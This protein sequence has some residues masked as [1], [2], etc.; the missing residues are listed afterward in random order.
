MLMKRVLLIALAVVVLAGAGVLSALHYQNYKTKKTNQA[1]TEAANQ[2]AAQERER[3][4]LVQRQLITEG[5]L[6]KMTAEC[7]KGKAIYDTYLPTTVKNR[8]QAPNCIQ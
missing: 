5:R 8:T 1:Q 6:Q 7:Q 4:Q 3:S 2:A